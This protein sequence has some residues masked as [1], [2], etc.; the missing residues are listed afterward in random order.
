MSRRN[1]GRVFEVDSGTL[2]LRRD[3]DAVNTWVLEV[4]GHRQSHV[5]LDDPTH[6]GFD[7]VRRLGHVVD[8]MAAEGVPIDAVHL[9]GGGLTLPRYIAATR[10]ASRQR[11]FEIDGALVAVV[12]RE[13]PLPAGSKI[14][15]GITDALEGLVSMRE[16]SADLVVLDVFADGSIPVH[17]SSGA[18]VDEARRV[19][20]AGG[21]YA[22]NVVDRPPLDSARRHIALVQATFPHAAAVVQA[23]RLKTARH[24]NVVV[25]G[26]AAPL[27]IA[28]LAQRATRDRSPGRVLTGAT[29]Q[30]LR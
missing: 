17:L 19:L 10:P 13:L 8:L 22:V 12:R 7:Y 24:G 26:S 4:D 16:A 27:P 28:A 2:L 5:D 6:L 30:R 25:L 21:I 15:V 23:S 1:A 11:V 18:V 3:P 9:G 14:R 29:L 20:R